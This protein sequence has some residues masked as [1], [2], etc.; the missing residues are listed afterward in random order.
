LDAFSVLEL[1][2]RGLPVVELVSKEVVIL[3]VIVI[4]VGRE[5]DRLILVI[6][7][8]RSLSFVRVFI[9]SVVNVV[10]VIVSRPFMSCDN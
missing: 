7:Y 6:F 8:R 2:I 5:H 3:V 1:L 9:I 10:I 4:I